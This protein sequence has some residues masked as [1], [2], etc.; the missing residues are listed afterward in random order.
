MEGN[1]A[2]LLNEA[3]NELGWRLYL[4][5]LYGSD[6]VPTYAAPGR[7]VDLHGL[8]ETLTFVGSIDP[9]R[10]ET[11]NYVQVL[12]AAGVNVHARVY[13]GC[14]HGF[15]VIGSWTRPGRDANAFLMDTFRQAVATC[16][17]PQS[18]QEGQRAKQD[19]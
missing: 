12:R 15:D 1:D 11:L 10:D 6:D 17:S 3:G 18:T 9:F 14:F 13:V 8:P 7:A 19:R 5:S 16:F 4:G 2:P